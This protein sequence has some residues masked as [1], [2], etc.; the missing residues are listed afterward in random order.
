MHELQQSLASRPSVGHGH[1][2]PAD[3]KWQET[4]DKA[5][6]GVVSAKF[7]HTRSFDGEKA[8]SSEATGFVVDAQRGYILTNRHVSGPNPFWGRCIFENHEEVDAHVIYYDPIHD[9]GILRFDPKAVKYMTL[10]AIPLRPDLTKVAEAVRLI[11]ND[12]GEKLS[13]QAA[14]ISRLDRNAP[15]Y[16]GEGYCDFN[17]NYIQAAS[18]ATGG[19]SGSPVINV[20]GQAVAMQAGGKAKTATD[21]FLPLDRPLRALQCLQRGEPITRGDIQCQWKFK[22][23]N[24][25]QGLGLTAEWESAFRKAFPSEVGILVAERVIPQGPSDLRIKVGDILIKVN[26]EL[27]AQFKDLDAVLDSSVGSTAKLLLQ[28]RGKDVEVEVEVQDLYKITPNRLVTVAGGSFQDLSYQR[29]RAYGVACKGVYLC[30]AAGSFDPLSTGCTIQKVD[31]KATPDLDAFIEVMKAIPDQSRVVVTYTNLY[32]PNTPR[33]SVLRIDRYWSKKIIQYIRN[34]ENGLW[35]STDLADVV[36]R[37]PPIPRAANFVQLRSV[38][39]AIAGIVKSIVKVECYVPEYLNGSDYTPRPSVGIVIDAEIGVVL[40]SRATVPHAL[41]DI[42]LTI[43]DSII[44]DGEVLFCHPLHNYALIKYD[45]MLVMAPLQSV[46]L[47]PINLEQGKSLH[48]VGFKDNN[49]GGPVCTQTTVTDVY[50]LQLA[51]NLDRPKLRAMNSEAVK[52]NTGLADECGSGLMIDDDGVVQAFWLTTLYVNDDDEDM[53]RYYGISTST[54]LPVISRIRNGEIPK[55]RILSVEFEAITMSQARD[56]KVSEEWISKVEVAN[57]Y[58]HQLFKVKKR[59]IQSDDDSRAL[60]EG[61]IILTLND[62]II[63]RLSETEIQDDA[64][65]L[66]AR[67]VRYG[68]EVDLELDTVL[69]DDFETKRVVLFCGAT[70]QPPHH[71]ARLRVGK[72]P[73]EVFV[74]S[75]IRGSPS[76]HYGLIPATFITHVNDTEAGNLDSFLDAAMAIPDNSNFTLTTMTLGGIE[77]VMKMKRNDHYFPT[78]EWTRASPKWTCRLIQG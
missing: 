32:D 56:M 55:L 6:A 54:I 36:A 53:Y 77:Q 41:C 37:R 63:T 16:D 64:E 39:P 10:I 45:P 33:I 9:F 48:F 28:R 23:F 13:I 5:A 31:N 62:N 1:A 78:K 76:S 14:V 52:V 57:S 25:C 8:I 20:F 11:G 22:P 58:C 35:E 61:D 66:K 44:V 50:N 15:E 34:D 71:A 75:V 38:P 73:S 72:S 24:E 30:N 65:V 60:L 74:S 69:A 68:E 26:G 27:L 49:I 17:T 19:S 2:N 59:T 51:G 3:V 43:A 18:G 4:V 47:S 70:L 40:V 7:C 46:T 29:A 42:A 21:F 67:V 12:A